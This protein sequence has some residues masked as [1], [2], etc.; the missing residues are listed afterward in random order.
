MSQAV[1]RIR[2]LKSNKF[3]RVGDLIFKKGVRW[4]RDRETVLSDDSFKGTILRSYLSNID[5]SE[6]SANIGVLCDSISQ[7][8]NLKKITTPPRNSL[9]IQLRTGDLVGWPGV[10]AN[11]YIF[12]IDHLLHAIE[13]H[14]DRNPSINEICI[15]TAMHF[16]D[17]EIN[18]QYYFTQDQLDKNKLLINNL[19]DKIAKKFENI[20]LSVYHRPDMSDLEFID[21]QLCYLVKSLNL[22][23]DR[24]GGFSSVI[25]EAR[26]FQ[27]HGVKK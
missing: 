8:C 10:R 7:F 16:G 4:E 3:Y 6:G 22:I 27:N 25:R 15:V 2:V 13:K 23:L 9:S 11:C 17:N 21:A 14:V 18:D 1:D 12:C 19:L 26:D 24:G 20:S 5:N